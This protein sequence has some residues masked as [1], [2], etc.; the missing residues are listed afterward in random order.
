MFVYSCYSGT[1]TNGSLTK[2]GTGTLAL[3]GNNAAFAGSV[4]VSAGT[5]VANAANVFNSSNAITVNTG[6]ILNLN[7]FNQTIAAIT[8]NGT[9]ALDPL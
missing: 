1:L 4:V 6:S 3:G 2:D 7:D 8:S 5:V 9:L